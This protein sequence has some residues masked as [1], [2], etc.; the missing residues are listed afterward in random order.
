MKKFFLFAL[1]GLVLSAS[2]CKVQTC[3]ASSKAA[4]PAAKP[5][6][7]VKRV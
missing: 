1:A 3:P 7:A 2:A 5:A 6:P 4:P